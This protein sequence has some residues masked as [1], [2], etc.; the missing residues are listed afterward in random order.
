L[1]VY[2]PL[3]V[4]ADSDP[5]QIVASYSG[6][7]ALQ[8][9]PGRPAVEREFHPAAGERQPQH[10]SYPVGPSDNSDMVS[11]RLVRLHLGHSI[12]FLL[13]FLF[14]TVAKAL[15]LGNEDCLEVLFI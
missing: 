11:C 14:V 9:D 12:T 4:N 15:Y 10:L 7:I 1:I 8:S 2:H 5:G 13:S 6:I 3:A